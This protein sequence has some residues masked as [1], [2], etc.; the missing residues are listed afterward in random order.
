MPTNKLVEMTFYPVI[1]DKDTNNDFVFDSNGD[2]TIDKNKDEVSP[3]VQYSFVT[4]KELKNHGEFRYQGI[5][6]N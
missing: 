3:S 4:I 5:L 2:K 1:Y 6:I